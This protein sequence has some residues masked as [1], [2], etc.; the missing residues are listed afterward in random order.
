MKKWVLIFSILVLASCGSYVD[1][2]IF[3]EW[4][5]ISKFHHIDYQIIKEEGKIKAKILSYND[6]TTTYEWSLENP[7]Y[8]FQNLKQ[9]GDILVDAIS[10]ATS[11]ELKKNMSV[12]VLNI[13]TL[14]IITYINNHPVPEL[15]VRKK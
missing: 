12:E 1:E 9:E 2:R 6:G 14:N 4:Q 5:S 11:K 8:A 15:W 10:G 7:K 3:G 13:D